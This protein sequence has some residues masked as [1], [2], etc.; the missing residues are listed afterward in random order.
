M[1]AKGLWDSEVAP[2]RTWVVSGMGANVK[3]M[4]A[5]SSTGG[6]GKTVKMY[7]APIVTISWGTTHGY[8]MAHHQAHS[9][10]IGFSVGYPIHLVFVAAGWCRGRKSLP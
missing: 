10:N 3:S 9:S 8:T 7:L 6:R 2:G 1:A 5:P 4:E